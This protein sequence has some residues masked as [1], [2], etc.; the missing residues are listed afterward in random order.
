MHVTLAAAITGLLCGAVGTGLVWTGQRGC[1]AVRGRPTCG[2][3][4][5]PLLIVI[6]AACLALGVFLLRAFGVEEAGVV[7]FF[8]VT[9]PLV[10]VLGLL[11]DYVFDGWMAVALP[12]LVAASFVVS[13]YLARALEAANPNPYADEQATAGG[14]S[15]GADDDGRFEG[16]AHLDLP[17]FATG[18]ADPEASEDRGRG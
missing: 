16:A 15:S 17:R 4:G 12:A 14:D 2:G 3:Y 6:I 11:I 18:D 1:D 8:G 7:A 9:L 5:L 13:V 10:V